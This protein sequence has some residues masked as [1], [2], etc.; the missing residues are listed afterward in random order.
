VDAVRLAAS[1]PR[2]CPRC[3]EQLEDGYC[4]ACGYDQG[5]DDDDDFDRDELGEDPEED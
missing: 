4:D 2:R 5:D 3:D 1:E